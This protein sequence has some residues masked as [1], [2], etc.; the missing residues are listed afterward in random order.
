VEPSDRPPA[1]QHPLQPRRKDFAGHDLCDPQ[2]KSNEWRGKAP[3]R[4][5]HTIDPGSV[6]AFDLPFA[7]RLSS[8]APNTA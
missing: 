7:I 5:V 6:Q 1:E 2:P 3:A 8:T 4:P